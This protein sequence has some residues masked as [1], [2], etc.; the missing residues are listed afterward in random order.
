MDSPALVTHPE[1][2]LALDRVG[3]R[4]G[5]TTLVGDVSFAVGAGEAVALVGDSGAGKTTVARAIAGLAPVAVGGVSVR[6]IPQPSL[7][8]RTRRQLAAVQ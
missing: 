8:R 6:D 7:G 4:V 2:L 1:R 5:R 3:V